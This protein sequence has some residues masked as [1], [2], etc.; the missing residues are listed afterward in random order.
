MTP[1][2]SI[3]HEEHFEAEIVDHLLAHGWVG[4][5]KNP[6]GYVAYQALY[7]EDVFD[8]VRFAYPKEWLKLVEAS[9]TESGAEEF[10]LRK[11]AENLE[12]DGTLHV[13]RKG[14][15]LVG[16][17]NTY[18]EMAS[19]KPAFGL[20]PEA[21]E[22]YA[23][24][25][26]RVVRQVHF[27]PFR[28]AESFDLVLFL[29]GI[30]V[31]TLEVKTDST[32]SV[33]DAIRQYKLDRPPIDPKT[34]SKEPLLQFKTR[35]LVHFA[36][37][38]D[39]A[40]MTTHLKGGGTHFLPFN[41]GHNEGAG[42]PPNPH[43]IKT[44]YL[45]EQVLERD[46]WIHILGGFI[47]L[48]VTEEEGPDGKT[49]RKEALIFPRY[50]QWNA[51]L[52]LVAAA[53]TE[54]AGKR[55]LV[56][57]SAGSGKSNSIAWLAHHL[58]SLHR[59]D[60]SGAETKVFKSVVII[61]DRTVLDK[62]LQATV[63]QFERT[64]G[65]VERITNEEGSK[66]GKLSGALLGGKQ[67]IIVTIQSFGRVLE[68]LAT[69]Q[70]LKELPFAVIA[71]E[72]H[73]SQ[74][75]EAAKKVKQALGFQPEG[76]EEVTAEDLLMAEMD[77]QANSRNLSYF[78]F[79]ATPKPKTMELFGRRDAEGVLRPFHSYSM[80]QA[81]EEEYILDV[82]QNYTPYKV[83]WKL[84]HGG[85]DYEDSEVDKSEATKMLVRWVRLHP[86][87]IAQKVEI[88]VEHFRENVAYRLEGQAKAM[89]VTASRQ[90][91]ARYKIAMD[92]YIR[93]KGYPIGT[94]VAFSGEIN[95]KEVGPDPVTEKSMN[96]HLRGRDIPKAFDSDEYHILLVANKYQT[97]FDQ[98]KLVA[99]YVDK[100]LGGVATVQTLS[101][102]NRIYPAMKKDWTVVID[103]V[104]DP[105]QIL[106]D[107]QVY[108]RAASMPGGSDP[109]VL[110]RLQ[111]KLDADGFYLASEV[112]AFFQFYWNPTGRRSHG[113]LQKLIAPPVQRVKDRLKEARFA[114]N[115]EAID[116]II[117]LVKDVGT[118][119]KLYEFL[120]Q[121]L[122]YED[123]DLAK[124]YALFK[125][126]LHP[127][128]EAMR[129][130]PEDRP[131][132]DLSGVKLTHYSI[133][134]KE[135]QELKLDP[136]KVSELEGIFDAGSGKLNPKDKVFLSEIIQRLND[137]FEG[138]LSGTD[139]VNYAH[140]VRDKLM[141]SEEL[142][143]QAAANTKPQFA[144]GDIRNMVTD[145]V[146]EHRSANNAMAGQILADDNKLKTFIDIMVDMAWYGFEERR[147][148]G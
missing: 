110:L 112:E 53:R 138:E 77:R 47:H 46:A 125:H 123:T 105:Q 124:R 148:T 131:H 11:L 62:Q 96:P 118:Y 84:A 89:V 6:S 79:T 87:N 63:K 109:E 22:R 33:H 70:S 50:H 61:T 88:I 64:E 58:A 126:I 86:H 115:Q 21:Q 99:M 104:N 34:R 28:P 128:K 44:S 16:T 83:A 49:I 52:K 145:A 57:H 38:T 7:P 140:G 113:E 19:F 41:L 59:T 68:H 17:G 14:F 117:M 97:G 106:E 98:K 3:H 56:Q 121:I 81:I 139:M 4:G 5:E 103:F 133:R 72:A 147:K 73:T 1:S 82:L 91:V 93:E 27:S 132:V 51:V 71:D 36:V 48:E 10:F 12:R 130:A 42:N 18:F 144:L 65:V 26:C 20:N 80:Q 43:G 8:W 31:A 141:E 78:A 54:G 74:T 142:A 30:P 40:Y 101:R 66:S 100:R 69:D 15:K 85:K 29:N 146:I 102:L 136:G 116:G 55:Y 95:D 2:L 122:N 37:S 75:G 107:F 67:I 114:K 127:L 13:L 92:R 45:W 143:Q 60:L 135:A 76:E 9:R 39:E 23:K 119:C 111:A 24:N 25:I 120:G 94:L 108:F 134:A 32:Q 35:C 129:L 137:L 90:E